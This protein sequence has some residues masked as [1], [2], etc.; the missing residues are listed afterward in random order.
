MVSDRLTGKAKG[1][2][3]SHVPSAG[4]PARMTY[5]EMAAG[6]GCICAA[7]LLAY[8]VASYSCLA[9]E[10]LQASAS[11]AAFEEGLAPA[12]RPLAVNAWCAGTLLDRLFGGSMAG[13]D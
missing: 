4:R 3:A 13:R 6:A 9:S 7:V 5:R 12:E 10:R 11:R 8:A 2:A 1:K